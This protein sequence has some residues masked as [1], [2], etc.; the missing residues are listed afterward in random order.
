[1]RK[2]AILIASILYVSNLLALDVNQKFGKVS[3]EELQM[4]FYEKDSSAEAVKLF[5]KGKTYFIYNE[6]KG[7]EMVFERHVRIKILKKDGFDY[8]DFEISLYKDGSDKEDISKLKAVTYNLENGK[9]AEDKLKR[10]E[11]YDV[12]VNNHRVKKSFSL[13]SVREGSVIEVEYAIVSDFFYN[14]QD[15]YFQSYI[16]TIWSEYQVEIPEYFTYNK[17]GKGYL[18]FEISNV[19]RKSDFISI[20]SKSR[21]ANNKSVSTNFSTQKIDFYKYVYN[22]A[23][24]D[25]PAMKTEDFMLSADNYISK[26]EFELATI[27]FPNSKIHNYSESWE[28]VNKKLLQHPK[29]GLHLKNTGFLSDVAEEVKKNSADPYQQ[30][31]GLQRYIINNIKWNGERNI[32]Q[33]RYPRTTFNEKEG[34]SA[35]L[36]LLLVLLFREAGFRADPVVLSTRSHGLLNP[37]HPSIS[38]MNHVIALVNVEGNEILVDATD[39]YC[40]PGTLP[41]QCYNDKGRVISEINNRWINIEPSKKYSSEL[42]GDFKIMDNS[43]QGDIAEIK[44][45]FSSYN[46]RKKYYSSSNEEEFVS[47]LKE[48]NPNLDFKEYEFINT[49]SLYKPVKTSYKNVVINNVENMGNIIY[50][51]PVVVDRIEKN[52]FKL[53]TRNYP[54]D[55]NYLY[56]QHYEF[57]YE[58]PEGFKIEEKPEDINIELPGNAASYEYKVVPSDTGFKVIISFNINK[59][60]LLPEDYQSLKVFYNQ[61][62]EKEK[63]QIVLEKS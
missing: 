51:N 32:F 23:V 4:K 50:F 8:A 43:I 47:S 29:F 42:T 55:Y 1:M 44:D 19:E 60:Q 34:N 6:Q 56:N 39:A 57:N 13:P 14:L 12:E 3:K 31:I 24:K 48:S 20:T 62:I 49:D 11:V 2:I 30:I 25:A 54:V 40:L 35:D 59:R 21:S 52:P 36:N 63:E 7:F 15:W 5:D 37:V 27:H 61:I 38:Q 26:V 10:R 41:P 53:D 9:V 18:A 45:G 28:S 58:L 17:I 46:F 33:T 22:Y 16:P